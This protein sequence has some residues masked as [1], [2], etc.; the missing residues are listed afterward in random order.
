MDAG[1]CDRCGRSPRF[2]PTCGPAA[3]EAVCAD[4][5]SAVG[6]ALWCD[7][8]ADTARAVLAALPRLPPE[9]DV[10][11]RLWWVATGEA[12]L[13]RLVVPADLRLPRPVRDAL[14]D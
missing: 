7:G 13:D 10:V 6:S 14:G 11:T 9:R 12:R 5:A 1:E 4:C 2:V 8:H 3:A